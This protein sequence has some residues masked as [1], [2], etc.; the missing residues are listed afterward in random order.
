MSTNS[1]RWAAAVLFGAACQVA[2][3]QTPEPILLQCVGDYWGEGIHAPQDAFISP[4]S[5]GLNQEY[6]IQDNKLIE[7]GG[8]KTPDT[9]LTLCA[10]TSTTYKY[11]NDCPVSREQYISD[12][13]RSTDITPESNPAFKRYKGGASELLE[14]VIVDRANLSLDWEQLTGEPGNVGPYDKV[15]KHPTFQPFVTS[16]RYSAQ[17]KLGKLKF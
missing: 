8:G 17:C 15:H 5:D 3:A 16:S 14:I 1:L 2:T 13:L 4:R 11:S 10:T 12:W 9:V 6:T 7:A